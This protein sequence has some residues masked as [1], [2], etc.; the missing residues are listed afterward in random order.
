MPAADR[1]ALDFDRGLFEELR[2]LRGRLA[3]ER[4]VRPDAILSDAALRQ[5]AYYI[6][7][8]HGDFPR[9]SGVG[10]AKSEQLGEAFITVIWIYARKHGLGARVK[11]A[12][13]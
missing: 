5:M 9:I 2:G 11:P 8:S 3:A 13:N 6:P 12:Y 10:R 1:A 4:G 7:V